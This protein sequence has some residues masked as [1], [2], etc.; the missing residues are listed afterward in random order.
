MAALAHAYATSGAR[1]SALELLDE[2]VTADGYRP[3]FEIAKVHLALGDAD[4]AIEW[5]ERAYDQ[6]AHSM[7]FLMVD[8]QLEALHSDLRFIRLVTRVGLEAT[9][10]STQ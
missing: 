1:E 5:L 9:T 7:A 3:S 10:R 2:L 6:H 8:P 4:Q